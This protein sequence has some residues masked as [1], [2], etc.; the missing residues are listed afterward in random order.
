M[1]YVVCKACKGLHEVYSRVDSSQYKC[2]KCI[3]AEL[4][5]LPDDTATIPVEIVLPVDDE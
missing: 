5:W 1:R 4:H 2:L 3:Q